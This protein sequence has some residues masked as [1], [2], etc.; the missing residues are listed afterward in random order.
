MKTSKAQVMASNKYN[1]DH[2]KTIC[3]RL[4]KETDQD[5]LE[6]LNTI[7]NMSGYIKQ[8]IR[9]DLDNKL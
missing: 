1:K 8:L 5:I 4:N 3:I 7:P 2:T 6:A 9:L